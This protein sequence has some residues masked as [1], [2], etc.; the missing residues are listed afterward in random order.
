METSPSGG[1]HYR[2]V[3]DKEQTEIHGPETNLAASTQLRPVPQ[4][5][6]RFRSIRRWLWESLVLLFTLGLL[7]ATIAVPFHYNG[8]PVPQ[9]PHEINLNT[10]IAILTTFMRAAIVMVIAEFLGQMKWQTLRQ[11]RPLADIHYFDRA[12]RSIFGSI[13]LFWTVRP[14]VFTIAA[15]LVIILS[16]AIGPFTQQAV[17]TV[18]C[19]RAVPAASASIPITHFVPGNNSIY[20]VGPVSYEATGDMKAAMINS[21]VNP[22]DNNSAIVPT[23]ATGN[24]TF[25]AMSNGVTHSSIGVCSVCIDATEFIKSNISSTLQNFSLPNSQSISLA[26]GVLLS[27]GTGDIEWAKSKFT[28]NF[29][30]AAKETLVNVTVLTSTGIR[31]S[32]DSNGNMHCPNSN[33]VSCTLYA[34][35]KQYSAKVE[36]GVFDEHVVTEKPARFNQIGG[37]PEYLANGA[38]NLYVN[39]TGVQTPCLLEGEEYQLTNLSQY[40]GSSAA[41]TSNVVINGTNHTIPNECLYKIE[42]NYARALEQFMGSSFFNGQCRTTAYA[43][44]D[45]DCI[46]QW[47]LIPLYNTSFS[48]VDLAFNQFTTAMTNNFR[49]KG[50]KGLFI[51]ERDEVVG[52]V[53]GTTVCT[54]F[55]WR[56]VLLPVVLV[57]ITMLLLV[58][59]VAQSFINPTMPVWKTSILPLLFHGPNLSNGHGRPETDLYELL[60]QARGIPVKVE[61]NGVI[62]TQGVNAGPNQD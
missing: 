21:L 3:G 19:S 8:T 55:N 10:I 4:Q 43:L 9:W 49:V 7:V 39:Q 26:S 5:P 32:S 61:D 50:L 46:D 27:V 44:G 12:N 23:C 16:P 18:A 2:L 34:C 29:T 31:C 30:E 56:W 60:K 42:L 33:A 14:Q 57:V 40:R 22:S 45:L 48:S 52:E 54:V 15:A 51:R 20:Q 28:P 24:C 13:Q 11:P 59:A 17:K 62:R 35:L 58:I 47:W 38:L 1:V 36:Q 53:I 41:G 25:P 6:T 37:R